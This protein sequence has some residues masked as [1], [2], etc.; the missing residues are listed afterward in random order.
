MPTLQY[1]TTTLFDFGAIKRLPNLMRDLGIKRPL[2]ATDKGL[3]AAGIVSTVRTA[4]GD[5][6]EVTIYDGTPPNPTEEAALE[7]FSLYRN[8][9][10]DGVVALGGGSAMDLGKAVALLATNDVPDIAAAAGVDRGTFRDLAPVI[11]VPTTAGTGS[12]VSVGFI[13]IV[14]DGRKLTFISPKIIPARAVCD[15][16]LTLG[17]PKHLTAATGMDA[18]THAIE[19]VL[20]PVVHPPAEAIGLDAIERGI[21]QGWLERAVMDGSDR[22]ARWH[23]MMASTEGALAFVKGLGAVHSMAHSAGR[24][25]DLNLHHGTLNAVI[26]P[27]V[28]RFN[29]DHAKDKYDR[30]R[31]ALRL[32]PGADLA[33]MIEELNEK[34]GMP[35]NLGEMGL[36]TDRIPDLVPEAVSDIAT[37][38][39]PIKPSPDDYARLFEEAIT[40]R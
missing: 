25:K 23:M 5:G 38:T 35:R 4:I 22:D 28:L 21:G 15:P 16:E 17:L 40:K 29:A 24:L 34:L 2:L 36:G 7:A 13:L 11:A 20:S 18:M 37:A 10:C 26:L 19:A 33:D 27:T 1:L 6:T 3:M 9:D 39:N 14:R 32:K 12:E 30:I 8:H 31:H